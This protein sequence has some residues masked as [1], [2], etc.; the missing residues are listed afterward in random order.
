MMTKWSS[1]QRTWPSR[2]S[3]TAASRRKK[4]WTKTPATTSSFMPTNRR[5]SSEPRSRKTTGFNEHDWAWAARCWPITQNA[6]RLFNAYF[7]KLPYTRLA[8][9]QQPA[10]NFGQ[11]WPTLI[12]MPFTAFHGF[13]AAYLAAGGN[14]R[15]ATDDFLEYVGAARDRSSV[16]GTHGWLEELSRSMDERRLC[17]VLS[18]ALR[19][20]RHAR[21]G[22]LY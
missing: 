15:F 20:A 18:L 6:T 10:G 2:D 8:L 16:V 13:N 9:T 22:S 3:T 17:R 5:H 11:A 7:G 4:F 14:I 19:S 12:Y 21:R 1:G